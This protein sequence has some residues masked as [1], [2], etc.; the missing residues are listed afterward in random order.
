MP[1]RL[2]R[3]A[4]LGAVRRAKRSLALVLAIGFAACAF[5]V[6]ISNSRADQVELQGTAAATPRGAY[7]ILVLPRDATDD[8]VGGAPGDSGL[9]SP[10]FAAG[11][12]G[13]ITLAQYHTIAGLP[14]VQVAAPVALIG[15]VMQTVDITVDITSLLTSAQRQLFVASVTR[16]SDQSLPVVTN[17]DA[18]Y[19]YVTANPLRQ[20]AAGGG[21][22]ADAPVVT[23]EV[24]PD[25]SLT[26]VCVTP[27]PAT[28][29]EQAAA[30]LAH[31][32][33]CWSTAPATGTNGA[34]E[35][36]EVGLPHGHV[37]LV[38]P[39][40]FP[41][42]LAAIDPVAE[43]ELAGLNGAVTEGNYLPESTAAGLAP[44]AIPV[45]VANQSE[46]D[47][48]DTVA[49]R[50]LSATA[51][52]QFASGLEGDAGP[53]LDQVLSGGGPV[54]SRSVVS[55][56]DA[57]A[58]LLAGELN[59]SIETV[60]NAYYSAGPVTYTA[61]ANG[62]L[63]VRPVP[64]AWSAATADV[65][66]GPDPAPDP[67]DASD[68]GVRPITAHVA[69]GSGAG[70]PRLVAVGAYAPARPA[71]AMNSVLLPLEVYRIAPLFG[72][73]DASARALGGNQ[74][75][76]DA[77]PAGYL[78]APP[79]L[80]TSLSYLPELTSPGAFSGGDGTAPITTIRVRVAGA[81]GAGALSRARIQAVADLIAQ[82]T[83]LDVSV[84]SGLTPVTR[85]VTLPAGRHGRPALVLTSIWVRPVVSLAVSRALDTAG[86]ALF[87]LVLVVCAM[88]VAN[89]TLASLDARGAELRLLY[90]SGWPRRRVGGL[91][92]AETLAVA[93]AAGLLAMTV[94]IPAGAALGLPLTA[95]ESAWSLPL[96]VALA[97]AATGIPAW[98]ACRPARLRGDPPRRTVRGM[99]LSSGGVGALAARGVL[100][101]PVR[102][103]LAFAGVTLAAGAVTGLAIVETA[104]GGSLIGE[105]AGHVL[106][107][108]PRAADLVAAVGVLVL[109]AG[110][111]S[112]LAR[113]AVTDRRAERALLRELGWDYR[114]RN[115]LLLGEMMLIVVAGA[116][117]G[118]GLAAAAVIAAASSA[119]WPLWP[120]VFV[121]AAVT[122]A[123]AGLAAALPVQLH[124]D[125]VI[126]AHR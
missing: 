111:I 105:L 31:Q 79:T 52:R 96:A 22:D 67:P 34:G 16:S 49:I 109:L 2:A 123:V 45:L 43:A 117:L 116:G 119:P 121:G 21:A 57:Y 30:Q 74:L 103:A 8:T 13:G 84:M 41:S 71:A 85:Q 51:A 118:A 18:D 125:P 86:L 83:G 124:H 58:A 50:Q 28:P 87:G 44:G 63:K 5:T 39:W 1:W 92:L 70:A 99:R 27:A 77:N 80:L 42:V 106:T 56:S 9:L 94:A 114:E 62:A 15:Q 97:V 100:R 47:D 25:G 7:D 11:Q 82:R 93:L 29:R 65:P 88:F 108:Q 4:L 55:A 61:A 64:G 120:A 113:L 26:P 40:T 76:P 60:V 78:T 10:N 17:P 12:V 110:V 37:G 112:D 33:T 53:G 54:L 6:L 36:S 91:L 72:A 19:S 32:G 48:T 90:Q 20:P 95:G 98:W 14:G 66:V 75:L 3:L 104:F 68:T 59:H 69:T 89:N 46:D 115:R 23:Q 24:D 38:I 122:I 107:L 81:G 102:N 73:N 126:R 35:A 101:T